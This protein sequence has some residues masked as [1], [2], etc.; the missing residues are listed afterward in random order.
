[1]ENTSRDT[2]D[3]AH[4]QENSGPTSGQRLSPRQLLA[5]ALPASSIALFILPMNI[6]IPAFYAANTQA[7]LTGIGLVAGFARLFDAITDPLIGYLSDL[8]RSR[9]GPRKPWLLV[10][11][12]IG[13]ISVYFLFQP[14]P[15]SGLLYYVVASTGVFLG[16]TLF[17]I[18]NRAWGMEMSH[19]YFQRAR[20][21][22]YLAV[23]SAVGSLIFWVIPIIMSP[24]TGSTAIT[25]AAMTG[26][27]WFFVFLF[28]LS[29]L[30]SV[31]FVPQGKQISESGAGLRTL[32][33]SVRI[34]KPL[35]RYCAA[36]TAWG[37]GNGAFSSVL[38]I[39]FADYLKLGNHFPFMMVVFFVVQTLTMPLW[40]KL[41]G[42]FGKHRSLAFSW[43]IDLISRGAVLFF[44]PGDVNVLLVYGLIVIIAALNGA[45]YIAPMAI[46]GDVIDYDILKT[47]K[48]KAASFAALNSL[49]I[50]I[51]SAIGVAV[52]LPTLGLFGYEMGV[53]ADY[54]AWLGLMICY[55]GIPGVTYMIASWLIWFFPIDARRHRT[56]VRRIES[57]LQTGTEDVNHG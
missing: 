39:L 41:I 55:V 56:I 50:K 48:N 29:T 8:T 26:I 32:I 34:N 35:W 44:V 57:R 12:V 54:M 20:I 13:S 53:E 19:D 17:E 37:V 31:S 21:S 47:G 25:P 9:L 18:P 4:E 27:A 1:M 43:V 36:V 52:A 46:L 14:P 30:M 28:P 33:Q 10:G 15:D 45:S 7:T 2:I 22:T 23:F 40:M 11:T 24:Y 6:V 38:L 51:S 16:F 49:L 3:M 42:R 5:Y